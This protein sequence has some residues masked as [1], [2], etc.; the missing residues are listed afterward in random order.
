MSLVN[1][2]INE[3]DKQN[4]AQIFVASFNGENSMLMQAASRE[5]AIE[6]RNAILQHIR[7]ANSLTEE[8]VSRISRR[9]VPTTSD[10]SSST[11]A[12]AD[13][14]SP[15]KAKTTDAA[16]ESNFTEPEKSPDEA[17]IQLFD[18]CLAFCVDSTR[19]SEMISSFLPTLQSVCGNIL[20]SFN[21]GDMGSRGEEYLIA[22]TCMVAIVIFGFIPKISFLIELILR[23]LGTVMI[24]VGITMM[25]NA[26]FELNDKCSPWLQPS[27]NTTK[28]VTG[29]VY[30]VVRHPM[31]GGCILLCF[32]LSMLQQHV[33]KCIAAIALSIVLNKAAEIE[34][35]ALEKAF[36]KVSKKELLILYGSICTNVFANNR[37]IPPMPAIARPLCRSSTRERGLFYFSSIFP[38]HD[39]PSTARNPI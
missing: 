6:W 13:S 21:T 3:E 17:A 25:L 27:K 29:G 10:P 34:E 38:P 26:A 4:P 24:V 28:I 22:A 14:A 5:E 15:S 16:A 2:E 36:P 1:T 37:I 9:T 20:E 39:H 30:G 35:E 8:T 7:F 31:Y 11:T 33:Y 32:G 23:L 12:A 18:K 19:R